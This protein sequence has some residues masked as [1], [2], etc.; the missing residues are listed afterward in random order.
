MSSTTIPGNEAD[1]AK[2]IDN[3][4]TKDLNVITNKEIDVHTS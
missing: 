4:V 3:L 1:M 2:M